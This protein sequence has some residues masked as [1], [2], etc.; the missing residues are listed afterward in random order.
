MTPPTPTD[1]RTLP[2]GAI[3]ARTVVI[4]LVV[5]IPL[6]LLFLWLAV[7]GVDFAEVWSA[8][9]SADPLLVIIAAPM[10]IS[11][12][13]F[14]G[15]RWRALLGDDAPL[16][17]RT[18]VA[19]AYVGIGV[20]NV[21]PGRPGDVVRGIWL[22]RVA[23]LAPARG[24]ASVGVDRAFDI[25]TLV[26]L[27]LA[28]LPFVA[29]PNWL[30]ALAITGGA[31]TLALLII[32]IAAWWYSHRSDRGKAWIAAADQG[33]WLSR[34]AAALARGMATMNSL[35]Q[36]AQVTAWSMTSWAVFT[37]GVWVLAH[38]MGI[39]ISFGGALFVMTVL[40]LGSAIP[41][42]P[43][44]I[45]TVQWLAVVSF[46]VLGVSKAPA[47]AF[48]VMLQVLTL[49]PITLAMPLLAWWLVTRYARGKKTVPRAGDD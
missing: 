48:S 8:L 42:S 1:E 32:L 30:F 37:A 15:L 17:R 46:A 14:Q 47:L 24:L 43:G 45:G 3:R 26:V 39:A 28:C 40:G 31:L 21:V 20:S 38:G 27:L 16:D 12:T 33:R 44:A 6:S 34:Q 18:Y 13:G 29:H 22:S 19:L 23:R 9:T 2:S 7:R 4:G 41:S 36:V 25:I 5:G 10:L 11:I 49:I 35:R